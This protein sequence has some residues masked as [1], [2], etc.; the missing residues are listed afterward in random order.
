MS[1]LLIVKSS[2]NGEACYSHQLLTEFV[3]QSLLKWPSTELITWDLTQQ[4]ALS[5]SV[6]LGTLQSA[7]YLAFALCSED[8]SCLLQWLD[9][10]LLSDVLLPAKKSAPTP[11]FIFVAGESEA[12]DEGVLRHLA[13]CLHRL[14]HWAFRKFEP[15]P[16]RNTQQDER[17]QERHSPAP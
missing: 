11:L 17:K 9:D 10:L 14:E 5:A 4:T 16:K 1:R 8:Y 6:S 12:F 2:P 7:D 13:F 3:R 15:H